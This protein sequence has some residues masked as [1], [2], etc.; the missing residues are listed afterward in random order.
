MELTVNRISP[1]RNF[2]DPTLIFTGTSIMTLNPETGEATVF[3]RH[4]PWVT[5]LW[6]SYLC[7]AAGK[8]NSHVDTWW[9]LG[10]P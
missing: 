2:W 10:C 7:H 6:L 9:V 3:A 4:Y 8:F 1:L 5:S